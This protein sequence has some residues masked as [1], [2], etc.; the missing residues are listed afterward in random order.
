M[1]NAAK[2]NK[3]ATTTC[4]PSRHNSKR[5]AKTH[6]TPEKT[7]FAA[8]LTDP[9]PLGSNSVHTRRQNG[10]H[11]ALK[12]HMLDRATHA[13]AEK[14]QKSP[15]SGGNQTV[16]IM[17]TIPNSTRRRTT[18][19]AHALTALTCNAGLTSASMGL[20]L[21]MGMGQSLRRVLLRFVLP[22]AMPAPQACAGSI[23][24]GHAHSHARI[25]AGN[26]CGVNLNTCRSCV[27]RYRSAL[28]FD[29]ASMAPRVFT[30]CSAGGSRGG[31]RWPWRRTCA[32]RRGCG[33][34]VGRSC[35]P[36]SPR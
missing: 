10:I 19:T 7:L 3:T 20:T 30:D 8:R 16:R 6:P 27:R 15:G 31:R 36:G 35:G 11:H 24:I 23:P 21:S 12:N 4:R 17:I 33:G 34:A 5:R 2:G 14:G 25:L 9:L 13:M 29:G 22:G 26:H 28:R 1:L 32:R 18:R